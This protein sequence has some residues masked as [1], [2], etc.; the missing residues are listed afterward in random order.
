MISP[1][2]TIT[3][4]NIRRH[5]PEDHNAYKK[6]ELKQTFESMTYYSPYCK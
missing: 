2:V 3:A 6:F 5:N 4:Y 1:V